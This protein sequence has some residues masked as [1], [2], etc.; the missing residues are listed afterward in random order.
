MPSPLR[1]A[2]DTNFLLD[3][4]LPKDVTHDALETMRERIKAAEIILPPTVVHEI[5]YMATDGDHEMHARAIKVI[6]NIVHTWHLTPINGLSEMQEAVAEDIASDLRRK[7][8]LPNAERND[9]E[10]LA[11]A[12][13]LGCSILVSA[14]V[15]LHGADKATISLIVAAH[16]AGPIVVS[17]PSEIVALFSRRR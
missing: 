1:I 13:A 16:N 2:V 15:D 9:T 6:P 10:I 4:A 12:A 7:R 8:V 14:D 3:L 11:E 17:K 5:T